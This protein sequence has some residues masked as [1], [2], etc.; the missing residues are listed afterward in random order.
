MSWE[1]KYRGPF[2]AFDGQGPVNR[3]WGLERAVTGHRE[4]LALGF[5]LSAKANAAFMRHFDPAKVLAAEGRCT[6]LK[7]CG[8]MSCAAWL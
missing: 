3:L 6:C 7:R 8:I 2:L 1:F 5:C 4:V